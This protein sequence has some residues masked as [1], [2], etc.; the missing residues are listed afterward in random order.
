VVREYSVET[1]ALSDTLP[2]FNERL[3]KARVL[4]HLIV[5]TNIDLSFW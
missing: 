4:S 5:L 3:I 1:G 2:A